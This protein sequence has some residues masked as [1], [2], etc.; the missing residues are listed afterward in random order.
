M[1]IDY[2]HLLEDE[3][4]LSTPSLPDFITCFNMWFLQLELGGKFCF[5]FI[6]VPL[7]K[8]GAITG[9]GIFQFYNLKFACQ[10]IWFQDLK[11]NDFFGGILQRKIPQELMLCMSLITACLRRTFSAL[12]RIVTDFYSHFFMEPNQNK[13]C[14]DLIFVIAT[15]FVTSEWKED[16]GH[17]KQRNKLLAH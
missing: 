6:Q 3:R 12:R 7:M 16:N 8:A 11:N 15:K 9:N 4:I 14:E 1:C 5:Y 10:D 17:N 13:F 2:I